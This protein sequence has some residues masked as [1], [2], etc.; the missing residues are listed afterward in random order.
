MTPWEN[1]I[2]ILVGANKLAYKDA[3]KHIEALKVKTST[4]Y[5]GKHNI[6]P[7]DPFE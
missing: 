5:K 3:I 6:I 2:A 1:M 4:K 7:Y